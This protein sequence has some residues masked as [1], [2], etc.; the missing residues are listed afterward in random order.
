MRSKNATTATKKISNEKEVEKVWVQ[1]KR[2]EKDCGGV[3]DRVKESIN[4]SLTIAAATTTTT[5]AAVATAS[6]ATATNSEN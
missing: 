1:G 4:N 6:A 3:Q 5:T 2:E